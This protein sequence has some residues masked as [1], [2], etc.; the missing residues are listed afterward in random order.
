MEYYIKWEIEGIEAENEIEAAKKALE[1]LRD[2]SSLCLTFTMRDEKNQCC[3]VDLTEAP[4]EEVLPMTLEEFYTSNW[5]LQ[6]GEDE[7]ISL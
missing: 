2:E 4:G 1:W 6:L 7:N 3:S 5:N